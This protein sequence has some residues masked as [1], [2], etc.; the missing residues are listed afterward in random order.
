MKTLLETAYL[1]KKELEILSKKEKLSLEEKEKLRNLFAD[2]ILSVNSEPYI[3]KKIIES[4][5]EYYY[6]ELNN[7]L[8]KPEEEPVLPE[9]ELPSPEENKQEVLKEEVAKPTKRTTKKK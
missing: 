4:T 7:C 8:L 6:K 2:L 9:E 1:L 3:P 5:R